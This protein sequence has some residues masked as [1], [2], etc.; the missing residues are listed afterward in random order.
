[1]SVRCTL[2]SGAPSSTQPPLMSLT[3]H[4]HMAI[5]QQAQR[6]DEFA[7][8]GNDSAGLLMRVPGCD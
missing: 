1:M 3:L 6:V 5:A 8:I 7:A 2:Y 4:Q